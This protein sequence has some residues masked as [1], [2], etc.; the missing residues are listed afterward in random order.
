MTM[1]ISQLNLI[2]LMIFLGEYSHG[3]T[4][5]VKIILDLDPCNRVIFWINYNDYSSLNPP[6]TNLVFNTMSPNQ[7]S[8]NLY[9][10]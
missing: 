10:V 1:F 7:L 4:L 3:T 9:A 5:L 8:I 6:F 2:S